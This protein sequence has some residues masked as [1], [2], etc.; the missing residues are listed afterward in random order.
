MDTIN[1][2]INKFGRGSFIKWTYCTRSWL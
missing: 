1:Q 2:K